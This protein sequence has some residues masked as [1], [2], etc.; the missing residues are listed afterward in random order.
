[1]QV[2]EWDSENM[3]IKYSNYLALSF[4][5]LLGIA[6]IVALIYFLCNTAKFKM[7]YFKKR[8]GALLDKANL[9]ISE[10]SRWTLI[11]IPTVFVMRRALFVFS[12]LYFTDFIVG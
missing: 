12:I 10:K 2:D 4:L 3:L 6:L 8:Y 9:D 7:D 11:F 1:M 5:V